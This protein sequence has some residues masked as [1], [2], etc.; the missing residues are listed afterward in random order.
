VSD[1]SKIFNKMYKKIPTDIN[2]TEISA[3]ITYASDFDLEFCLF[4]RERRSATLAHMPDAALEVE[5]NILAT[6]KLRG[7]YDI[8]RIKQKT[9]ASSSYASG[10]YP[11]VDQLTKL[12]KSLST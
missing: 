9:K 2:P 3:K 12:V 1:F 6:Y 5:S 4:L 10:I 8:D 7:R 11:K